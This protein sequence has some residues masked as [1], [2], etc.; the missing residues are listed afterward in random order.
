M[1]RKTGTLYVRDA[2]YREGTFGLQR[3]PCNLPPIKS[4]IEFIFKVCLQTLASMRISDEPCAISRA[5]GRS[6]EI[7]HVKLPQKKGL[8]AAVRSLVSNKLPWG[9]FGSP[10]V[11]AQKTSVRRG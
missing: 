11:S 7:T 8:R 3:V 6:V 1:R 4:A 9:H 2:G 10:V 5:L